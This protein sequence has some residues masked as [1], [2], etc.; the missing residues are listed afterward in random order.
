MPASRTSTTSNRA[1]T[2]SHTTQLEA[3]QTSSQQLS[4]SVADHFELADDA[5]VPLDHGRMAHH[6]QHDNVALE[7][8]YE[9]L[10]KALVLFKKKV[11]RDDAF[12]ISQSKTR[13]ASALDSYMQVL[14][15]DYTHKA[16]LWRGGSMGVSNEARQEANEDRDRMKGLE[17]KIDKLMSTIESTV[18]KLSR[19]AM[20]ALTEKSEKKKPSS[21]SSSSSTSPKAK[22]KQAINKASSSA[23]K[24]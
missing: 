10:H 4:R 21:S 20:K 9:V 11:E 19:D 22:R 2:K 16:L 3:L 24:V 13:V 15:D 23:A 8:V 6:S 12:V 17:K 5:F 18:L 7:D 1:S 14:H